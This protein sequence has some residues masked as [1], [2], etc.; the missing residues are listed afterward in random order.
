MATPILPLI[1]DDKG[2]VTVTLD[3]AILRSWVYVGDTARRTKMLCAHEYIDGYLEG[4]GDGC[5][6]VL[7]EVRK[8]VPLPRDIREELMK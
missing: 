8:A 6:A 3:G 2:N 1:D 7:E 5:D 4:W